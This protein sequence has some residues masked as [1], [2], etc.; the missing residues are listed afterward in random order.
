MDVAGADGVRAVLAGGPSAAETL[1]TEDGE[2]VK[3]IV[4]GAL[5]DVR[6]VELLLL[7]GL[8]A[9]AVMALALG[10]LVGTSGR[11]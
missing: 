6:A 2:P 3:E 10:L 9:L 4:E 1:E 8:F 7:V 11:R 5:L